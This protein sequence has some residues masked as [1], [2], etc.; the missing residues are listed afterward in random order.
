MPSKL[1]EDLNIRPAKIDHLV[2]DY[3][4][5]YKLPTNFLGHYVEHRIPYSDRSHGIRKAYKKQKWKIGREL[6]R[7]G[8]G[9]VKLQMEKKT[10]EVRAVK[11][12]PRNSDAA[13]II[14]PLR[15]LIAMASLSKVSIYNLQL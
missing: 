9:V 5:N 8:F 13:A 6:G 4:N 15:E 2:S 12:V 3:V 11:E 14:D 7:G 10:R 1:L